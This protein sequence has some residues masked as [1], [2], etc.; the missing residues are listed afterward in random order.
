MGSDS[1]LQ[2]NIADTLRHPEQQANRVQVTL[3]VTQSRKS[4][5]EDRRHSTKLAWPSPQPSP[6]EFLVALSV[7]HGWQG[8]LGL[9]RRAH[10]RALGKVDGL[11]AS[12]GWRGGG[13]KNAF[14]RLSIPNIDAHCSLLIAAVHTHISHPSS[15]WLQS[16]VSNL[17]WK[18]QRHMPCRRAIP[19]CARSRSSIIGHRVIVR[20][21]L[22]SMDEGWGMGSEM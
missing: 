11:L 12:C 6:Q 3:S 4:F 20:G 15:Q 19:V 1:G 14:M 2:Q 8:L 18:P 13:Q 7:A 21:A 10:A 22:G 17:A 5:L 9:P 16:T